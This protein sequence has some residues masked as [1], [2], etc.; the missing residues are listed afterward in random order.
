MAKTNH[1]R[2]Y[3]DDKRCRRGKR[4]RTA[5][6]KEI[7]GQYGYSYMNT[8][9]KSDLKDELSKTSRQYDRRCIDAVLRGEDQDEILWWIYVQEVSN[10]WS[11]D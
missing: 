1:Q 10:V 5:W 4:R 2:G 8:N 7:R 11:W 3:V 6:K 9:W